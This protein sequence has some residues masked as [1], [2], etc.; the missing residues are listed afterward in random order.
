MHFLEVVP[1]KWSTAR[2]LL[3]VERPIKHW[4]HEQGQRRRR[5]DS[6]NHNRGERTLHFRA[7]TMRQS[8][9]QKSKRRDECRHEHGTKPSNRA[10]AN[11]FF[12]WMAFLSKSRNERNHDHAVE[13]SDTGKR[14]ETNAGGNGKRQT[15][16]PK[17]E[18]SAGQRQRHASVNEQRIFDVTEGHEEKRENQSQCEGHDHFQ[19]RGRGLQLFELSAP[20]EPVTRWDSHFIAHGTLRVRNKRAEIAPAHVARNSNDSLPILAT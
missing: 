13:D 6:A 17:R 11:R 7:A 5:K 20:A 14:N 2:A 18:N 8:H 19:T 4:K 12:Q 3:T 15:A 10:E 16:Q 9:G 1:Y